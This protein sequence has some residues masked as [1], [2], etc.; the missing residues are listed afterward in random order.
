MYFCSFVIISQCKKVWPFQLNKLKS[1][2][3]RD[4]FCQVWLKLVQWFWR[5][6]FFLN[7]ECFFLLF[8][9]YLPLEKGGALHLKNSHH[10]R[11]FCAKFGWNWPSCSG[12]DKLINVFLQFRNHL[13]LEKGQPFIWTNLNPLHPQMICG[14]FSWHWSSGSGN[15]DFSNSLMYFHNFVIISPR[16][17]MDR[18][19]E[20]TWIPFTQWYFV[21]SLVEI[22]PVTRQKK[23]FF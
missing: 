6:R 22:G 16:K 4:I 14:K 8:H 12:E 17:T 20:Y 13:P 23:I 1:S 10:S 2:L 18:P 19:F 11:M 9:N 7:R 5:R 21:P 3:P 15:D